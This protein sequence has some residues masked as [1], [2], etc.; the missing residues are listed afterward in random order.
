MTGEIATAHDVGG[1][2]CQDRPD[3]SA[4]RLA[5]FVAVEARDLPDLHV[6]W[7]A[8]RR[9]GGL[10]HRFLGLPNVVSSEAVVDEGSVGSGAG[11]PEGA[12]MRGGDEH[13]TRFLHPG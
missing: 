1:D 7:T 2:E 13:G 9:G 10:H 5:V 4:R 6:V 8:A 11:C 3:L 12:G